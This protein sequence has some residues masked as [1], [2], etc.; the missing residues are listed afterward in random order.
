MAAILHRAVARGGALVTAARPHM[1]PALSIRLSRAFSDGASGGE[2]GGDGGSI[3]Y[4][5]GQATTGQGG[6]YGAGGARA[7][8]KAQ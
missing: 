2:G 4:S 6:F 7:H 1:C 5:G 8:H 3:T